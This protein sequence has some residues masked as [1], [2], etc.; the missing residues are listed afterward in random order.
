MDPIPHLAQDSRVQVEVQ[1]G[2]VVLRR[3]ASQLKIATR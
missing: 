1:L 3:I 2:T